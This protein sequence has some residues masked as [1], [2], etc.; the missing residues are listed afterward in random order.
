[1]RLPGV[2]V[3]AVFAGGAVPGQTPLFAQRASSHISSRSALSIPICVGIFLARIGSLFPAA[4]V[5]GER[6]SPSRAAPG[7]LKLRG[8][9]LRTDGENRLSAG[10]TT[11]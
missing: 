11:R 2:A 5:S 10:A 3:A 7:D 6:A 8:A 9:G 4:I 1:M